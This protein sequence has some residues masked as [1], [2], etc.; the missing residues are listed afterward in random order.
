MAET[1]SRCCREAGGVAGGSGP[2]P[3]PVDLVRPHARAVLALCLTLTGRLHDAEDLAQDVFVRA[4]EKA[5]TLRDPSRARPWLLQIARRVCVD[6]HRRRRPPQELAEEPAVVGGV[7]DPDVERLHAALAELPQ[8]YR[9]PI[10][11]YYLENRCCREI[12]ARLGISESAV[13]Q[14]LCRA[15][16][17]LHEILTRD[18]R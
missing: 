12:A 4:M 16:L 15:R 8:E 7:A 9:E 11:L 6:H 10:A 2:G 13:R 5:D 1:D 14:R 3:L 17:R 18:E